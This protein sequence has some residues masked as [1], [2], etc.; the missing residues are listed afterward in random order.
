MKER[1]VVI[2]RDSP[3]SYYGY[4]KKNDTGVLV[5]FTQGYA[6]VILDKDHKYVKV[7]IDNLVD[8]CND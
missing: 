1:H 7:E 3:F 8:L 4:Y 5:G 2:T 6:I